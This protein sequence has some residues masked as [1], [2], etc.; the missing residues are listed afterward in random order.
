MGDVKP[1]LLNALVHR[2]RIIVALAALVVSSAATLVVPIAVRKMID[3]GFSDSN[4][5]FIRDYLRGLIGV[6]GVVALASGGRYYLVTT[7]GERVVA[8]LRSDL[9]AHLTRLDPGF[10]D[11]EKTGEIASRL[12]A[13]T[14]QLKATFGSSASIALRNVFMFVGAIAMMVFTSPKLSAY[15][16]VAIP[17]IVLPLYAAGRAVRQRSR[18]AQDTLAEATAFAAESLSA[19]RVMQSFLAEKFSAGRYREA[20]YGA[21]EAARA[22]AQ[23]RASVTVAAIFLAFSSVVVVLWL[24]AQD[25]V[26]GRMTGVAL[27]QFVLFAV[28]GAGAL[29]QLSA[30]WDEMSQ[31]AGPSPRVAWVLAV[32]PRIAAPAK[33]VALARP[34]RGELA[35]D[36]VDFA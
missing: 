19:V 4:A 31:G 36:S 28:F 7:L 13:D 15:V 11:A 27:S 9:F 34:I 12:S 17:A 30:V 10:F 16:V 21:Y 20:A 35:F 14:T 8:D 5:A 33:P 32:K 1:M 24:G 22:M 2:L 3:Y 18:R 25:V 26:A 23:A 6:V 29:G